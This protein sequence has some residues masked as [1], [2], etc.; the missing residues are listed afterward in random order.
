MTTRT[1]MR[2]NTG[3]L[4]W[5]QFKHPQH[6]TAH[7]WQL[8]DVETKEPHRCNLPESRGKDNGDT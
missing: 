2:C 6:P 8:V 3:G 1:C 5:K 7:Y 4:V